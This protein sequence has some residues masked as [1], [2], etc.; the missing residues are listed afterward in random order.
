VEDALE[1]VLEAVELVLA[2]LLMMLELP[3]PIGTGVRLEERLESDKELLLNCWRR[4]GTEAET[5]LESDRAAMA[6]DTKEGIFV[7]G[8]MLMS[9]W[10][11]CCCWSR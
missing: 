7:L 4:Y 9:R 8:I 2:V 6:A 5:T 1:P 10:C 11:C 3:V